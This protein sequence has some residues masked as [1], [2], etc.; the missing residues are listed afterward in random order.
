VTPAGS[1]SVFAGTGLSGPPTAGLATSSDLDSPFG[2]AVDSFRNVYIAD[3]GNADVE[4]VFSGVAT[5]SAGTSTTT[6]TTTTTSGTGGVP[7]SSSGPTVTGTGRAGHVLMCSPGSW[8]SAPDQF[9]YQWTADGTPIAG[10]TNSTYRVTSSDEQLTIRCVVVAVNGAGGSPPAISNGIAI[11]VPKVAGCPAATGRLA[12]SNL[13]PIRLGMTRAQAHAAFRRSSNRGKKYED[14]FCLTPI[15]VRVGYGSPTLLR[16]LLTRERSRFAD[17]VVWA[18]TASRYYGIDG[19][20]AGEAIAAAGA[21][22]HTGFPFRI[23]AND[24]YLARTT[25]ST[26][27]LKVRHGIVEEIGI[28]DRSLTTTRTAQHALLTSFS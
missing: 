4:E 15:G 8:T 22:L 14:F 21:T 28:A 11:P 17:R 25:G 18:S 9:I 20:R 19:V 24:W 6:G 5:T 16:T 7:E 23:G 13:G 27:V 3:T 26:V 10:A 1:L 12:G 2:V